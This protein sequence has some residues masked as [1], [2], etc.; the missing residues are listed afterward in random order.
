MGSRAEMFRSNLRWLARRAAVNGYTD[1]RM[2]W[3]LHQAGIDVTRA[4]RVSL[5]RW[6]DHGIE[7]MD[8]RSRPS[9]EKLAGFF[10]LESPEDFWLPDL[11][12]EMLRRNLHKMSEVMVQWD[13]PEQTRAD[14]VD[15]V[16]KSPVRLSVEGQRVVIDFEPKPVESAC[17]EEAVEDGFDHE[18]KNAQG[19]S[20]S[21]A[22]VA[23]GKQDRVPHVGDM[24]GDGRYVLPDEGQPLFSYPGSKWK[25]VAQLVKLFPPHRHYVSLFGGSA[26]DLL[27]KRPSPTETF[28]DL[29]DDIHNLFDVLRDDDRRVRLSEMVEFTPHGRKVFG[30]ALQSLDSSDPV[31]RAWAWLVA[32]AEGHASRSPRTSRLSS[33]SC[34]VGSKGHR[35]RMNALRSVI[36]FAAKRLRDVQLDNRDWRVVLDKYDS[37]DTFFFCDPPYRLSTRQGRYYRHELSDED[38]AELLDKLLGVQ[39]KVML[40]GNECPLYL[41]ALVGWRM[42]RTTERERV[43]LNRAPRW[44]SKLK[45]QLNRL[46]SPWLAGDSE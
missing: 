34:D 37:G 16:S 45:S 27:R 23:S 18:L 9:L 31:V 11:P 38:H 26:T 29:D 1:D 21:H 19:D 20:G 44:R 41:E 12:N 5:K 6:L 33:W 15:L 24:L 22:S 39:G 36:D 40:F 25:V 4:S 14:F 46:A 30:D 42:L 43:W 10:R 17:C 7:Q 8:K 35:G 28:N 13:W 32:C 2:T 3:L